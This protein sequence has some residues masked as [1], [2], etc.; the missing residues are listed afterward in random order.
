MDKYQEV[1]AA[2]AFELLK[3]RANE[4]LAQYPK[5]EDGAIVIPEWQVRVWEHMLSQSY[6]KLPLVELDRLRE[7]A[8]KVIQVSEEH[9]VDSLEDAFLDVLDEE[10][11]ELKT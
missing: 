9:L 10:I 8:G 6:H 11:E 1:I 2:L 3:A 4:L 7:W 5:Q